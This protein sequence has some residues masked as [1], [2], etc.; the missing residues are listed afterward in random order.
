M[1]DLQKSSG[2]PIRLDE[3]KNILIM[4]DEIRQVIPDVRTAKQMKP[5]LMHP[6]AKMPDNFYFMYR[7]ICL[8]EHERIIRERNL[9]YDM[10]VIP[11]FNVGGEYVKTVGH[12]HPKKLGTDVTYPELYEVLHGRVHFCL[13]K[14]EG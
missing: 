5:V 2:L 4:E 9:R 11:G 13:Q 10:T 7:G 12:F 3:K 6:D 1:I 8:R 14:S